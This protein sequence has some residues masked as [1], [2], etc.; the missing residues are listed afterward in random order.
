MGVTEFDVI[1]TECTG[2]KVGIHIFRHPRRGVAIG[3]LGQAARQCLG[4]GGDVRRVINPVDGERHGA[5]FAVAA[6]VHPIADINRNAFPVIE[7]VKQRVIAIIRNDTACFG[8]KRFDLGGCR[9]DRCQN[10]RRRGAG[11]ADHIH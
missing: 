7:T 10:R 8:E 6:R 5:G 2:N 3:K 4:S 9:T 1:I 11:E